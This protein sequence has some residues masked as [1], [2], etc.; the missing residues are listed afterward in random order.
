MVLSRQVFQDEAGSAEHEQAQRQV[1]QRGGQ[2]D[3]E[4]AE[5]VQGQRH[6]TLTD[7]PAGG[8]TDPGRAQR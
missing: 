3:G 8:R 7:R 6:Q 1:D 5:H 4:Q 2:R